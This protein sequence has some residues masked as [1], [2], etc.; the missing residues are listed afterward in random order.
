MGLTAQAETLTVSG[1]RAALNVAPSAAATGR[2]HPLVF[3]STAHNN[4]LRVGNLLTQIP[5]LFAPVFMYNPLTIPDCDPIDLIDRENSAY[6][7]SPGV[8]EQFD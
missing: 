3:E 6:V 8:P 1:R 4:D 5:T 7:N 2:Q